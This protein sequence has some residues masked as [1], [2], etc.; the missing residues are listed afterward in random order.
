[1]RRYGIVVGLSAVAALAAW[2]QT[3]PTQGVRGQGRAAAAAPRSALSRAF[4]PG[5]MLTDT[6]GDGLADAI[7]GHI[8]VPA[9]PSAAENAAAANLAARLAYGS[10]GLTPPLVVAAAAAPASGPHIYVGAG[11]VPAP[12]AAALRSWTFRLA[13]GEGR[14]AVLDPG[15]GGDLVLVGG[16][17]AGLTA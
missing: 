16:D 14:V 5:W 6:N 2:A 11:A 15:H 17:D 13:K 3:R 9:T 4:S 12:Q 7:D 10:S 1:M 8:V